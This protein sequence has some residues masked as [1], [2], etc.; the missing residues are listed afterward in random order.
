MRKISL[1]V[2]AVLA[3]SVVVFFVS[4]QKSTQV[5]KTVQIYH[6]Q[7]GRY[8]FLN[9]DFDTMYYWLIS[10]TSTVE[11]MDYYKSSLSGKTPKGYHW[12]TVM[13]PNFFP[14]MPNNGETW[15]LEIEKKTIPL[16]LLFD[17]NGIPVQGKNPGS[18]SVGSDE[19]D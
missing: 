11:S 5:K 1:I 12:A 10:D 8:C 15:L 17:K 13:S 14:V 7:D 16:D 9:K 2:F 19:P 6:L 3:V 18:T 4:C